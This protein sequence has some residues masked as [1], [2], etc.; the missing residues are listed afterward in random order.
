[1]ITNVNSE[2][3]Y[4]NEGMG[5]ADTSMS[6]L[7]QQ[8]KTHIVQRIES[9]EW[10]SESR[11]P[12]EKQLVEQ[13]SI[14]RSTAHRALRELT[15]EGYLVRVQGVGTFVAPRKPHFTLLEIR[16]IADE[17]TRCGGTHSCDLHLLVEE[18]ASLHLALEMELR[19]GTPIFHSIM[20]HRN[21]GQ[22]VQLA[23]RYVNPVMAPNYLKQDF[24]RITPSEYLFQ[25]GPL[26]EA[27][28]TIKAVAP[29]EKTRNLLEMPQDEP[30]LVIHRRTW[31]N[32]IVATKALLIHPGSRFRPSGRFIPS[33]SMNPIVS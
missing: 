3:G 11:I 29:D 33:S 17:I 5:V 31:S 9:G 30:C 1:M 20:V 28:H 10:A 26:T 27:E 7:F 24:T 13:F 12:S 15:V 14:S 21:N 6:P 18:K 19:E 8:V 23:D 22:P 2:N 16:S 4:Q 32:R 25:M